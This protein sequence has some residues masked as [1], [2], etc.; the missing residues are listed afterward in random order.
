MKR[1]RLILSFM[2]CSILGFSQN[3]VS[4]YLN[5]GFSNMS[6][7]PSLE[8]MR[9]NFRCEIYFPANPVSKATL[10]QATVMAD[11]MKEYPNSWIKKYISTEVS[12]VCNGKKEKAMGSNIMLTSMQKSILAKAD[13]NTKVSI[14]IKY[15]QEN[16]ATQKIEE[17]NL[18][19]II[20]V[21]PKIQATYS[22]GQEAMKTYF[23]KNA[24]DKI[25]DKDL[26]DLKGGLI[27]FSVA[28]D[29]KIEAAK[30]EETT[31][32]TK[33]DQLFLQVIREMSLWKPAKD[34]KGRFVKQRFELAMN[35]FN[36]GC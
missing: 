14:N 24:V 25:S 2:F 11:L 16:S 12:A 30:L 5:I 8:V 33:V 28:K 1:Y 34:A 36:D 22:G 27:H 6:K 18:N 4:S 10:S 20:L 3:S 17:H 35:N 15:Q 26:M 13:F 23:K 19:Y 7:G 21:V 32:N 9:R 31:G 29:G